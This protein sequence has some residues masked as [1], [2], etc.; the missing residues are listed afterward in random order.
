MSGEVCNVGF[1]IHPDKNNKINVKEAFKDILENDKVIAPIFKNAEA[2]EEITG[3]PLP[4]GERENDICGDNFMLC[5]DAASLIDPLS[6]AGI[7]NAVWS[8]I[9][10]AEQAIKAFESKNF[11]AQGLKA[12]QERIHSTFT[13]KLAKNFRTIRFVTSNP[14]LANFLI[15]LLQPFVR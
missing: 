6:G 11:A 2:L 7:D 1:G 9:F 8:G 12:Y 10:A 14:K 5:G 4:V 13:K 15:G 3:A